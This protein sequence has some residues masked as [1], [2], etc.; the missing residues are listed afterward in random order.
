MY[1]GTWARCRAYTLSFCP[2]R[3]GVRLLEIR[4]YAQE[5]VA[6]D[7]KHADLVAQGQILE[8]QGSTRAQD[9][10]RSAQS[11]IFPGSGPQCLLP[12]CTKKTVDLASRWE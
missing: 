2:R 4:V 12:R 8:L 7:L 6:T 11:A 1:S 10:R 5:I 3:V 9:R